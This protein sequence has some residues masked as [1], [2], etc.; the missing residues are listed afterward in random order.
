MKSTPMFTWYRW[1][2]GAEKWGTD[3]RDRCASMLRGW[4][5]DH[6]FTLEIVAPGFYRVMRDDITAL[7]RTR[8]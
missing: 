6:R 5:R 3:D 2:I 4:R 8:P 7:I 1:G